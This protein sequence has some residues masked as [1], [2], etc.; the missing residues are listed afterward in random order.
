M[1]SSSPSENVIA[2][3]AAG[4]KSQHRKYWIGIRPASHPEAPFATHGA[5]GASKQPF[6]QLLSSNL[7]SI[8][9][10]VI[11]LCVDHHMTRRIALTAH[12][13]ER[14]LHPD[15]QSQLVVDRLEIDRLREYDFDVA[16]SFVLLTARSSRTRAPKDRYANC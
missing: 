8:I 12:V 1:H 5:R 11:E 15:R 7:A 13:H 9:E 16:N 6:C 10:V 2:K 4:R 3:R 14:T